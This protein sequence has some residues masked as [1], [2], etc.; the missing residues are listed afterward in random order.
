VLLCMIVW[1]TTVAWAAEI[2]YLSTPSFGALLS[3]TFM[4]HGGRV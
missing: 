1:L 3:K 2:F 4:S